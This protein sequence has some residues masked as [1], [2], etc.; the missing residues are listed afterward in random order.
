MFHLT[1]SYLTQAI[2]IYTSPPLH[3]C[4]P[5]KHHSNHYQDTVGGTTKGVTDKVGETT[6]GASGAI[7]GGD[8]G[9]GKAQTGQNPLGL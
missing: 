9:S 5:Y 6:K 3:I 1:F 8:S 4:T 7:P 2:Y